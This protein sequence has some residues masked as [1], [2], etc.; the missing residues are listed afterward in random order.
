MRFLVQPLRLQHHAA[1]EALITAAAP[2]RSECV[3]DWPHQGDLAAG[4]RYVRR[5]YVAVDV[6]DSQAVIGYASIWPQGEGRFRM[7]LIVV[8][9]RRCRGVG[10][11]LLQTLLEALQAQNATIVQA[12]A[13]EHRADAL[14]F[15]THRGFT[16]TNRMV[17][18]R[19]CL[20]NASTA[21]LPTLEAHLNAEGIRIVTL[22]QE[23]RHT[24]DWLDRI[25][26]LLRAT[27]PERVGNPYQIG[28]DTE[29]LSPEVAAIYWESSHP[30]SLETVFIAKRNEQYV[31]I[32]FL[33][34]GGANE[35]VVAQGETGVHVDWRRQGIATLLKLHTI[36]YA[37]R[38]GY[39]EIT[40]RTASA[41]MYALN[42]RL[43]FQQDGAE[44]R[45]VKRI[46]VSRTTS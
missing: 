33:S 32:S 37:Q 40:T 24:A 18:Q 31:G 42:E 43:G 4:N 10:N 15:L 44:I 22:E 34:Q 41:G 6:S 35:R 45:L 28:I 12:R 27:G 19:L 25:L 20:A 38:H 3:R 21:A 39:E 14:A 9:D 11:A 16:E 29:Y 36:A 46:E 23:Q 8:Q 1:A 13:L 7:D 30:L 5:D 17:H 26:E 2:E